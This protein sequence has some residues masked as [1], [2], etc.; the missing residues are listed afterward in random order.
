MKTV[1]MPKGIEDDN[2]C[3]VY[4]EEDKKRKQFKNMQALTYNRQFIHLS[5]IK[6]QRIAKRPYA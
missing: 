4:V 5:E 1:S 2:Q 6:N 3:R